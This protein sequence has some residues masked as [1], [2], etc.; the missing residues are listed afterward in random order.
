MFCGVFVV[1]ES[2]MGKLSLF[3]L[4]HDQGQ[5]C[6]CSILYNIV[7]FKNNPQI[8]NKHLSILI[9]K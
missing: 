9:C 3:E 4:S 6:I 2:S 5:R 1:V 8:L 7:F